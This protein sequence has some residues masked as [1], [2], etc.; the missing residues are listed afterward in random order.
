LAR[1]GIVMVPLLVAARARLRGG[2]AYPVRSSAG[3]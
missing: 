1:D 2:S 3:D